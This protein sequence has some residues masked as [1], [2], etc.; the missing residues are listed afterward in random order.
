L[1]SIVMEEDSQGPKINVHPTFACGL[2]LGQQ[3]SLHT[4][5][6]CELHL[7][8]LWPRTAAKAA[9]YPKQL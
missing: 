2:S 4:P 8:C 1:D 7:F 6:K 9:A 5:N 3:Q